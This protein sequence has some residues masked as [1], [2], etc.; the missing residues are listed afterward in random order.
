LIFGAQQWLWLLAVIPVLWVLLR[1]ADARA[2]RRTATLLGPRAE[3]HIEDRMSGHRTW[4]RVLLAWGMVSLIVALARP[5]WGADEVEVVQHGTDVVIAL[6]ISNSMLARDVTPN[7]LVRARAEVASFLQEFD[8]GQVGLVLFAG[9]AFVQCPLTLDL[10]AVELFLRM[11]DT[12]MI[13]EQGTALGA[14]LETSVD[15]LAM[16]DEAGPSRR[17]VILV[18]DGENLE[19]GWE[20]A[21]EHCR[22]EDVIVFPIGVG[23]ETGGL[24]PVGG[25]DEGYMKDEE[26][27]V[28]LSR[29]DV[30]ALDGLARATGGAAF[31]IGP[32][33][34]DG[35]GLAAALTGL[36]EHELTSRHVAA[37]RERYIWPLAFAALLFF[38]RFVLRP[39]R[40]AAAV[41]TAALMLCAFVPSSA[42]ALD[43][44]DQHGAD[45][46]R[47][48][49]HYQE[50]RFE[51]ALELFEASRAER[52][53]DPR[54]AM[55]VGETLARL[56]RWDEAA[57]E[58]ERA[59]AL[60]DDPALTAEGHYNAGTAALNAGDL[61]GAVES[62][63]S[64]LA[65]EPD[66]EDALR[67]LEHAMTL[68]EQ[69]PPQ[70]QQGEEGE[71]G[72]DSQQQQSQQDQGE[73]QGQ[74]G[75]QEQEEQQEQEQQQDGD[76][77]DQQQDEGS[78]Q[79]E[80]E[81]QEQ[82]QSES[83]E[84]SEDDAEQPPP[85]PE[86]SEQSA[87]SMSRQRAESILRGLDKDEEELRRS[88]R[89]RLKGAKPRSGKRW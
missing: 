84:E 8:H 28:V 46:N 21:A 19:G 81:D 2:R 87:E 59:L 15:M 64:S 79:E 16:G 86:A 40:T 13:S 49:D 3:A 25:E 55:A 14:A 52:P 83:E 77:Q 38:L 39:R 24:V 10:G 85:P 31:R 72:E 88:V 6:D 36:G 37:Y 62:L 65:I 82:Q 12:D 73:G 47:A 71:Q 68:F 51:E 78:E 50:G 75:Q 76:Q 63:R 34:L 48:V 41:V 66:S 20:E 35:D 56:D 17:A 89:Q 42:S 11:A 60:S 67:N 74:Q 44:L 1:L 5:Q 22:A 26:G 29:L 43:L 18:T 30:E 7:R 45:V 54:L 4:R 9:Q 70:Q 33:S 57:R 80:Q 69:Q 27:N 53:D 58:F 61:P 32:G 23:L